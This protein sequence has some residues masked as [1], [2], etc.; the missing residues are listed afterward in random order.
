MVW[1]SSG[2]WARSASVPGVSAGVRKGSAGVSRS[3]VCLRLQLA[4]QG[5][6]QHAGIEPLGQGLGA[7]TR[8]QRALREDERAGVVIDAIAVVAIRHTETTVLEHPDPVGHALNSSEG[9]RWKRTT[10]LCFGALLLH[11]FVEAFTLPLGEYE[12]ARLA[13]ESALHTTDSNGEA[14]PT[15][16]AAYK[17]AFLSSLKAQGF[18]LEAGYGNATTDIEAYNTAAIAKSETYIIGPHGGKSGTHGA[19]AMNPTCETW[20]EEVTR[21]RA[22]P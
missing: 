19:C 12:I 15:G 6:C 10:K 20:A 1:C 16:V 14:L 22:L 3:M 21:L 5:L 4:C 17:A 8:V 7:V 18:T 2:N 13:F 9:R 11:G